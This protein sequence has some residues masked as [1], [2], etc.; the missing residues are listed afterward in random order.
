VTIRAVADG[1]P[2]PDA[3]VRMEGG[4]RGRTDAAGELGVRLLRGEYVLTVG[5]ALEPHATREIQVRA[6]AAA[7]VTAEL[8]PNPVVHLEVAAEWEPGDRIVFLRALGDERL[9]KLPENRLAFPVAAGA[10][11]DL[12]VQV[13][14]YLVV[15]RRGLVVPDDR[16]IVVT[17]QRGTF[18]TGVCLGE[19]SVLLP[20]VVAE[21]TELPPEMRD[22]TLGDGKFR[23]GPVQPGSYVLQLTGRNIRT[24]RKNIVVPP[25]GI[26]VGVA[27]LLAPSD[28]H[29][30][31]TASDGMPLAGAEARTT[32]RVEARGVTDRAGR[33]LLP[34]T[35]PSELLRVRASGFLDAWEEIRL[36]EDSYR[37]EIHVIL[38][39]PARVVVRGVDREGRPVHFVEPEDT[40]LEVLMMR[41]DQFLLTGVPP[42][43]LALELT[44]RRGRKGRLTMQVPEGE[45]RNVT[46]TLE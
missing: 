36:T 44:D 40:E 6:I 11:L 28:L 46:V 16:R 45:Q 32:Y 2:V 26:D 21:L 39:R 23:I 5:G 15:Y 17:P 10:R 43:P 9:V 31:V 41:P 24:W 33:L 3:L 37:E 12:F 25:E 7:T 22:E 13:P 8:V 4:Y 20:K 1:K 29:I 19:G 18:V 34:G 38:H 42:G 14:G 27:R 30:R 35:E